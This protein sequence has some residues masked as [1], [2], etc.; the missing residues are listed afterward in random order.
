MTKDLTQGSPAKLIFSFAV[1]FLIGNIFQQFYNV[2][3][4]IIVGRILGTNAL[5]AVGATGSI[6][7]FAI[8][9]I[10]GLTAGF[11]ALTAQCF[12][13]ED[14]A[15]IKKS[16]SMGIL[17]SLIITVILTFFCL[18]YAYPTLRLL[19]TPGEIIDDSYHYIRWIYIGL[20]A[21]ALFNLLSNVI[22]ALGDS[23]TPLIFLVIACMIN[24]ILDFVFIIYGKM[25]PA[26]TGLA[27]TISQLASGLLCI[28]YIIKKMPLLHLKKQDLIP[29]KVIIQNLLRLGVPMAFLNMV[30]SIGVIVL[31]FVNNGLG[32]LYVAAYTTATKIEQFVELP[33]SSFG[34]AIAI[35]TAQNY[36]A[37]KLQRIRKGTNQ[38]LAIMLAW[39]VF[40]AIMIFLFG[41]WAIRFIAGGDN[42]DLIHYGY[43]YIVINSALSI[44]LFPLI[45]YKCVLQSIGRAVIP[46]ISGFA[47]IVCRA[48][49]AIYL[50]KWYGFIGICLTNP[51]AWLGA[52]ILIVFDYRL[53]LRKFK[54]MGMNDEEAEEQEKD[55]LVSIS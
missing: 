19:N 14:E 25:G 22:R 24:I 16:F 48:A 3:D 46:I 8:G 6:S 13:A 12:G 4:T 42:L 49:T 30:L 39:S 52:L 54:K 40:S 29:E 17:L 9:G 28:G 50:T 55:N 33:F 37:H 44:M 1:P 2:A 32:T 10:G 35:Y 31:Q 53:L 34:S 38:C 7:W 11:S 21:T 20:F 15:G 41:K 27:T 47:E 18:K 23:I 5:A 43:Q 36:G 51:V 26:G 45:I